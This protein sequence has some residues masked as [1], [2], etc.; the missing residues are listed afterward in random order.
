VMN[1]SMQSLLKSGSVPERG[2]AKD[3][4]VQRY[5]LV[6]SL[7]YVT[8]IKKRMPWVAMRATTEQYVVSTT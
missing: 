2:R 4:E 6:G 1:S 5:T 8:G 3:E 7:Y